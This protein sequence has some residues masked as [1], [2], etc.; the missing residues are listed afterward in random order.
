MKLT[1]VL[2]LG[3]VLLLA[4]GAWSRAAAAIDEMW[5]KHQKSVSYNEELDH[6][7]AVIADRGGNVYTAGTSQDTASLSA[8]YIVTK[9]DEWGRIL[10][11]S[12]LLYAP[13]FA[14]TD[15]PPQSPYLALD[16]AGNLYLAE[17][18]RY[19]EWPTH[20]IRMAKYNGNT[21]SI[22]W[23]QT[24]TL[25]NGYTDAYVSG[26]VYDSVYHN[27]YMCATTLWFYHA[28]P[29]SASYDWGIARINPGNGT[30]VWDTVYQQYGDLQANNPT[31]QAT[32]ICLDN[33]RNPVVCGYCYNMSTTPALSKWAWIALNRADGTRKWA[34]SWNRTANDMENDIPMAIASDSAGI[35]IAGGIY[36]PNE[37]K[38]RYAL[39]KASIVNGNRMVP[40]DTDATPSTV[41]GDNFLTSVKSR[42]VGTERV[43][44]AGIVYNENTFSDDWLVIADTTDSARAVGRLR[45]KW[46]SMVD[47]LGDDDRALAVTLD[48]LNRPWVMGAFDWDY[49]APW[50]LRR[51]NPQTGERLGPDLVYQRNE[52]GGG[53]TGFSVYDTNHIYVAGFTIDTIP[54]YDENHTLVRFSARIASAVLDSLR[55]STFAWRDTVDSGTVVRP[56]VAYHSNGYCLAQ[57]TITL[58]IGTYRNDSLVDTV[59]ARI[60]VDT[61][62]APPDSARLLAF[63]GAP[64]RAN[65]RGN[66]ALRCTMA[67]AGDTSPGDNDIRGSVFVRVRDVGPDLIVLTSDTVEEG[68]FA[69]LAYVRNYGNATASFPVT[70][71]VGDSVRT[72]TVTN[73]P[74]MTPRAVLF[75]PP[76]RLTRGKYRLRA[77]TSYADDVFRGNDTLDWPDSLFVRA[78]DV[79]CRGI[80]AP[81]GT[82]NDGDP[83]I[84]SAA[85]KNLG[86]VAS[87]FWTHFVVNPTWDGAKPKG[88][89]GGTGYRAAGLNSQVATGKS[90][91]KSAKSVVGGSSVSVPQSAF[92]GKPP[93][94]LPYHESLYVALLPGDSTAVSFP[95]WT[96][97]PGSHRADCY[98]TL[99]GDADRSNDTAHSSI[100][101]GQH[102]VGTVAVLAPQGTIAPDQVVIPRA[103]VRNYGTTPESFWTFFRIPGSTYRDSVFAPL[104]PGAED[105]LDFAGWAAVPGDYVGRCS[106]GLTTDAI[107]QNDTA[108]RSFHV[109]IHDVGA[110]A[111]L[112]PQGTIVPGPVVPRAWVHNYGITPE[113]FW[114]F[115]YIPGSSYRDSVFLP[116]AAGADETLDFA[117]WTAVPGDYVG[118]CS[119]GLATDGNRLND[120]TSLTFR[121][122]SHDVG[123]VQ[124][125]M[126]DTLP[127]GYVYPRL[128]VH[129]YGPVPEAFK[130]FCRIGGTSYSDSLSLVLASGRDSTLAFARWTA[131]VGDYTARCST[132]LPTDGNPVN[133]TLSRRF[134]VRSLIPAGWTLMAELPAGVKMKKVKDGGA[135][136]YAREP[137]NDT[138]FVYAFKGNGTYEFYRYNVATNVW[139]TRESIPAFN[140]LMKKKAVKKGAS[141][142]YGTDGRL[143]ATKGNGT[144]DFWQYDPARPEGSRW[145]QMADV[146]PGAKK[147]REGVGSAA[148]F[149]G[150]TNHVYLLKGSSTYEFYRYNADS[151][152]WDV[153]LPNAPG[154]LS[155]KPYKNGSCLTCDGGDT[156]FALKGTYNEFF[157]Y[158]IANQ[159]WSTLDTLP[160]IAPPG[161]RKKKVKDGAGMAFDNRTVYAL[162]GGNTDEFWKFPC[163]THR[164]LLAEPMPTIYR[165]VKGGGALTFGAECFWAFRGNN[166]RE[167]WRYRSPLAG[168][169]PLTASPSPKDVQA[170]PAIRPPQFALDVAPNPFVSSAGLHVAY[171]LPVAGSVTLGLY[172]LTGRMVSVLAGGHQLAGNYACGLSPADCRLAAGVYFLKLRF[173]ASGREQQLVTKILVE[174]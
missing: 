84:P 48:D 112:A 59:Y 74:G 164:W 6:T 52:D 129:N 138:D 28:R 56:R 26:I 100:S 77:F 128:M 97:S 119:T 90:G 174:R 29:E 94:D 126:S 81:V 136:A 36:D 127:V 22:M 159:A 131:G 158:S 23:N 111:V 118:R 65:R 44:A 147:L 95:L 168:I 101:V 17:T 170:R 154:G 162:K 37:G 45:H 123:V 33:D 124:F 130:V 53:P 4:A 35:Y 57:P 88:E 61:L 14:F 15:S 32:G 9:R 148:V 42:I 47:S 150:G 114:A 155:T 152:T 50:A 62:G 141:L 173:D 24:Y 41:W 2:F 34:Q 149:D 125:A 92:S 10:W 133:D 122:A 146:P 93:Q 83:V 5:V 109:A 49:T 163:D 169:M 27:L 104:A 70:F 171:S 31:D 102:D 1:R 82:Y 96:A 121:V 160:R 142:V 144:L 99:A 85:V 43:Y 134:Y 132:A 157:A 46:T 140:S 68:N 3:C 86:N 30:V 21:G 78:R 51:F 116:L 103:S 89:F 63:P 76:I 8:C 7:V 58:G 73:L 13:Y 105:T 107:R 16:T 75:P 135:L 143:Y 55:D 145:T 161:S 66:W 18:E 72:A 60:V 91:L 113:N 108:S 98:T 67:L 64:W 115:F 172:D 156:I 79:T 137:G 39:I 69:P 11:R 25:S 139:I 117:S 87:S 106:T 20:W 166:T 167:F 110:V 153:P 54:P 19:Q 40:A 80:I 38:Y 151:N 165:K 71:Q 120:T 12:R